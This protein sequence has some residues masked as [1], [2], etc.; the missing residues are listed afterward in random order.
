MNGLGGFLVGFIVATIITPQ[1]SL[2]KEEF[3][4]LNKQ[5]QNKDKTI[6]LMAEYI[7][8][9][10]VLVDKYCYALTKERIKQYF[11]NKAKENPH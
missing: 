6:D 5:L 8:S 10:K 4:K 11:E 1:Y 2:Y 7:E 9:K 3:S